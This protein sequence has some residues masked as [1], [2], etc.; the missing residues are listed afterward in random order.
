MNNNDIAPAG[1]ISKTAG[2]IEM[3]GA[4][5]PEAL[6]YYAQRASEMKTEI[7]KLGAEVSQRQDK[8]RM[9]NDLI[10]DINNATDATQCLDLTQHPEILE[11]IRVAEQLGVKI[12]VAKLHYSSM[13][14]DR[15][16]GNLHLCGDNWDKL[17]KNITQ[18][19]EIRIKELD[20]IMMLLKDIQKNEKQAVQGALSGIRNS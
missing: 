13:E 15:L 6:L 3:G 4:I 9:I 20:R 16:I 8:L 5:T 19:M 14:R 10:A 11:K 12:I 18:K 7:D 2:F 17:N 1:T